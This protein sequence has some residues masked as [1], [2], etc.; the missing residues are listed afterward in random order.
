MNAVSETYVTDPPDEDE[1]GNWF[2]PRED[3][4]NL[5]VNALGDRIRFSFP[6]TAVLWVGMSRGIEERVFHGFDLDLEEAGEL[7]TTLRKAL[8]HAR[9]AS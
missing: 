9:G 7:A 3:G 6:A 2:L 5:W 4:T 1:G 8:R